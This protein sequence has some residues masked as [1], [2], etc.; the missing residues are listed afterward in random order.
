M[1]N[2]TNR[3]GWTGS[4]STYQMVAK[5]IRERYGEAEAEKYDP[6]SNCFTFRRWQDLGFRVKKGERALKSVTFVASEKEDEPGR[7]KRY[8]KTV[9]L[10]YRLQVEKNN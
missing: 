2:Q 10:F 6:K 3:S 8:L 5:Q 4:Q 1:D 9:N 7:Q